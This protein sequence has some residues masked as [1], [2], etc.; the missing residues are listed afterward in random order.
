MDAFE[1]KL[2]DLLSFS[3]YSLRDETELTLRSH[4]CNPSPDSGQGYGQ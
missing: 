2:A 1:N 3:L 4:H